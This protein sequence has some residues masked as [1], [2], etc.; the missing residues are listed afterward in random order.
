[1]FNGNADEWIRTRVLWYWNRSLNQ[2]YHNRLPSCLVCFEEV[3]TRKIGF[4][5]FIIIEKVGLR[6]F[7]ASVWPDLLSKTVGFE[8][9]GIKV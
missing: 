4:L 3:S 5:F 7:L 2:V 1:M 6:K 8:S 9:K